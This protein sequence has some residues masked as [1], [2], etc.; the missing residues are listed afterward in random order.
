MTVLKG[1]KTSIS[2]SPL[3][4]PLGLGL[5]FS[6]YNPANIA[7]DKFFWWWTAPFGSKAVELIMGAMP[8]YVLIKVTGVD[9]E[10]IEKWLYVIV[11]AGAGYRSYRHRPP[12]TDRCAGIPAAGVPVFSAL[13]PIPLRDDRLRLQHGQSTSRE[14]PK[15]GGRALGAGNR[16]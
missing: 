11:D 3:A 6:F 7:P 16:A 10:V 2:I 13:E 15:Q 8:A 4:R 5:L 14:H 1:R 9:R 12:F